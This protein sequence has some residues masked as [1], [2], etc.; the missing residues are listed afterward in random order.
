V[1][2][3]LC[4]VHSGSMG[5][6]SLNVTTSRME[7][8]TTTRRL[9]N[10]RDLES[11]RRRMS[12]QPACWCHLMISGAHIARP[13]ALLLPAYPL[14]QLAFRASQITSFRGL[15]SSTTPVDIQRSVVSF[16]LLVQACCKRATRIRAPQLCRAT[17]AM[18]PRSKTIWQ[19]LPTQ[20]ELVSGPN[21]DQPLK[22]SAA[23]L[24]DTNRIGRTGPDGVGQHSEDRP[25]QKVRSQFFS[26]N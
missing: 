1:T 10:G 6:I 14:S 12:L 2:Y 9:R 13:F 3:L 11:K 23:A 17:T 19:S 25:S 18:H 5:T 24:Y 7:L 16:A 22:T 4:S 21:A 15:N 26:P 20:R 8:S